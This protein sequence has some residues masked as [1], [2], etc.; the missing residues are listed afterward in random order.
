MGRYHRIL[1]ELHPEELR[2]RG[3]D[4]T[5]PL[6]RLIQ[7]GYALHR[8]DHTI[9]ATR[10][11]IY[12]RETDV[13]QLLQPFAPVESDDWPHFLCLA[14]GVPIPGGVTAAAL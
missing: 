1:I 13:S 4:W 5:A 7:A 10:R 6:A 2:K 14:P 3:I 11:T 8:I 9:D 12:G